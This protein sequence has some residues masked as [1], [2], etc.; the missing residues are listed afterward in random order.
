MTGDQKPWV[1]LKTP[2]DERDGQ[3]SPDGRFVAYVSDESGRDEIY[4]RPFTPPGE[5]GNPAGGQ[6]QISTEGGIQPRWSADAREL[7]YLDPQGRIMAVSI[8]VTGATV[9]PGTPV[10]LF[11]TK[12]Y[13]GG[14]E[15]HQFFQYAV[16]RDGRFLINTV[17]DENQSTAPIRL[18]L[19]WQPPA[20]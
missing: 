5:A 7:Y 1:F 20:Q 19:N 2:F 11:P 3:F 4:I 8:T 15:R 13:E 14:V 6:W 12:I 17:L 18:I 10:L 9:A 16:A